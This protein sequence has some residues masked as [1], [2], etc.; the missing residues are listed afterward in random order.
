MKSNKLKLN[1]P[2]LP[3]TLLN[4]DKPPSELY[5][6]GAFPSLLQDT[7]RLA[8][9]G[10][11]SITP[12]GQKVTHDIV[13]RLASQGI[14]IISGLAYGVDAA[15][16]QAALEANGL[17]MAVLP[18]PLDNIA[19]AGNQWLAS[20]IIDNSGALV[21]EYPPGE[22]AYKHNFVLRNRIVAGL[23][24]ALLIIEAG[25]KSGSHHTAGYAL[26]LGL[27]V[28]VVPGDIGRPQSAGCN[29]LLKTGRGT[30]VT[31][32]EDVLDIMKLE[33]PTMQKRPT[34]GQTPA[35]QAII[36]LLAAGID[37]GNELL[38]RSKLEVSHFNQA[39]T[40]LEI[41]DKIIPLGANRWTLK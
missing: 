38:I 41:S 17:T 25:L 5:Y 2:L 22:K 21:S 4:V 29:A 23:S 19:P 35:E 15:A 16:H 31:S 1:S 37:E 39:L 27:P 8:V 26:E 3:A 14:V 28:M 9:V 11:R 33:I 20:Q 30:A 36:D 7:P 18:G 10:T 32:Y 34:K 24:H 12:Y 6:T 40:V 13:T